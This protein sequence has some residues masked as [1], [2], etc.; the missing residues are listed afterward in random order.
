ML[1]L[2]HSMLLHPDPPC[3]SV[4]TVTVLTEHRGP[5]RTPRPSPRR[6]QGRRDNDHNQ[7]LDTR[8]LPSFYLVASV[9]Q[10]AL[11]GERGDA[12]LLRGDPGSE[13]GRW[14]CLPMG[15][16]R[17]FKMCKST[18]SRWAPRKVVRGHEDERGPNR[19]P[20]KAPQSFTQLTSMPSR[21]GSSASSQMA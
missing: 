16:M 13:G 3:A 15:G 1:T 21:P 20:W 4:V 6:Q 2:H 18:Q 9:V 11:P 17:K 5:L 7:A 8:H 19:G 14:V 12:T 10:R